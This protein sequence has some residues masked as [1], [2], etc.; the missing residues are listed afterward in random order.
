MKDKKAIITLREPFDKLLQC[1]IIPSIGRGRIRTHG[2]RKG[3]PVFKTG[4]FGHSATLPEGKILTQVK[5]IVQENVDR[6]V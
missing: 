5:E 1:Q 4:A 3:T 6:F 2:P